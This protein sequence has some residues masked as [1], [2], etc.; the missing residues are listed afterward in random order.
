MWGSGF[1]A[2]AALW[3]GPILRLGLGAAGGAVPSHPTGRGFGP[4]LTPAT[5][6]RGAVGEE[7]DEDKG[8]DQTDWDEHSGGLTG[9]LACRK[10]V[11]APLWRRRR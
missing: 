11:A 7:R 4:V 10:G 2:E 3:R 9:L 6:A 1:W 8:Q 5:T